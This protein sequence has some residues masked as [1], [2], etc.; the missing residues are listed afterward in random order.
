[1]NPDLRS[2]WPAL[3]ISLGLVL[4]AFPAELVVTT[5]DRTTGASIPA[6]IHLAGPD[7]K[8]MR[9]TKD[10]PFWHDHVV[11][12]GRAVFEVAAGRHTLTVERGPE[13]SS[14]TRLLDVAGG[15]STNNLTVELQR[16][17][18]LAAEGWWSGEMHIHRPI[19]QVEL[20]M[21]AED[22]HFGQLLSWW[23]AANPWTNNPL[24]SPVLKQFDGD[25]FIHQL[26]GED[27][28]DGGALLFF[29]LDRP[30]DITAGRQHFPSSLG[31]AQQAKAARAWIDI[32]KP[33]WWDMP[34][35]I[36]NGI[37]DSIGISNNHK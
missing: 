21:R 19:D 5:V 6:R 11:S 34:T 29:N 24:P 26:G 22:L 30:I 17:T 20:L 13:W 9:A 33:F 1:M 2:T 7:G 12:P 8:P 37:G 10:L 16:V 31:F 25:R 14:E 3:F 28:R 32:E 35:W 4:Q 36:A 23:N 27:E 15:A 18:N